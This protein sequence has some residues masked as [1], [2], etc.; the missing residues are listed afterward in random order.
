[1]AIPRIDSPAPCSPLGGV[2]ERIGELVE[3]RGALPQDLPQDLM[4]NTA[5]R[6]GRARVLLLAVFPALLAAVSRE[7]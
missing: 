2:I 6:V 4:T 7:G 1:L 3:R 5:A